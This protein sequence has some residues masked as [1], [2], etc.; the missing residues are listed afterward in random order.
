M[1]VDDARDADPK[2][3][4]EQ[5]AI[6]FD[7]EQDGIKVECTGNRVLIRFFK[8]GVFEELQEIM[9]QSLGKGKREFDVD[10]VVGDEE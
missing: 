2:I 6:W 1:I 4:P 3:E 8:K 9:A 7:P 5:F 10:E